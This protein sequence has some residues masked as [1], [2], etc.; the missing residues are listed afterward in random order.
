MR[1][2][3]GLEQTL[4]SRK[5]IDITWL[6]LASGLGA[7]LR[8]PER[9][10]I[11]RSIESWFGPD[12]LVCL[13]VR[14]GFDLALEALALPPG[15]EVLV[16][17][18][19]IPDMVR[20]VEQHRLVPVPVDID[21]VTLSPAAR[22]LRRASGPKTRAV[23]VAHLFGARLDLAPLAAVAREHEW[24]VF[25]DCAQAFA[26]GAFR[27]SPQAD[28]S[29]FSFGPI[30]TATALAGGVLRVR[31]DRLRARLR[32]L[33]RALPPTPPGTFVR[34]TFKYAALKALSSVPLFT[35]FAHGCR[36][37]RL[38][39]D[40]IL[41]SMTR[42]FAGGELMT[43]IRHRPCAAQLALLLRRLEGFDLERF[44]RRVELGERLARCLPESLERPGEDAHAHTYWVFPV[45]AEDPDGLVRALRRAGFDA[46]R[47]ATLDVAPVPEAAKAS[48]KR[49]IDR[50]RRAA[51]LAQRLVYVPVYPELSERAVVRLAETLSRFGEGNAPSSSL[52]QS[53]RPG[54]IPPFR[55]RHN[56][57]SALVH[58][59][60]GA[61]PSGHAPAFDAPRIDKG[62]PSA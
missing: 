48:P 61:G 37:L 31:D 9:S 17:A 34:R 33:E 14:T 3:R 58:R 35:P 50:P 43:R 59:R 19:T 6:D 56:D 22:E 1:S 54:T 4:Y 39:T 27:G 40:S 44:R 51:E 10:G 32:T 8:P 23:L 25:E 57:P 62:I 55:G 52:A 16:S 29:M 53:T 42:G 15:S 18:L 60:A 12:A 5:R 7:A 49:P 46:T 20:I 47:R 21:P 26:G 45:L 11:E 41:G 38:D 28:V 2:G 24:V 13:S 36:W 30:K